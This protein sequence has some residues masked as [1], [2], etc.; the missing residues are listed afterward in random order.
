M[1]NIYVKTVHIVYSN[2]HELDPITSARRFEGA[3]QAIPIGSGV[4]PRKL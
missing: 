2:L 3:L 4:E 1:N